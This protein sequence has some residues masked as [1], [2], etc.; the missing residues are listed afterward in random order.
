MKPRKHAFVLASAVAAALA[1]NPACT[2][3]RN[4]VDAEGKF[5]TMDDVDDSLASMIEGERYRIAIDEKDAMKGGAKPVVTIVEFS[6]FQCPFCS[7]VTATFDE[8]IKAFPEDVRLVFKQFPLPMH[9]DAQLAAEASLAA[10]EQGKFWEFHDK[11]FANQKALTRADLEKYATELALDLEKFKKALDDGTYKERVKADMELGKKFQVRS[12]PS[13]FVN[14]KPQKGAMNID[15]LKKIVEEEKAA[16]QKLVD[17][18]AKR[19][20]IY[21]RIMRAAKDTR[22]APKQED[23]PR[24]GAPDPA[25]NYAVTTGEGRP[26][27]GKPDA[28]VT[29]VEFSDFQCP[30]CSRVNPAIQQIKDAHPNDVRI[31]FKQLPLPMHPQ[32]RI[33]A[34]ASLAADRQGKFWDMYDKLFAN[35][36]DL[37]EENFAK[38][39]GEIGLNVDKFK[40]DLADPKL[41]D[42]TKEDEATARK[43]GANG[44]PAFFVNGRHLSGAQPFEKFDALIKEEKAKAEKFLAEKKV[45]KKDLYN[46][47]IKGFET[48]LKQ[49]PVADHKRR[50]VETAGLPAK[51]NTK[52]PKVTIV[53]CSDFDCPFCKRATTTVDQIAKE[54]GDK[55]AIFFRQYPLP[56]HK[57]AEPAHRAA[58]AAHKQGKFWEM[59]DVLFANKDKRDDAALEGF[60]QQVGL[61]VSKWKS[62]FND[63]ATAAK[64]QADIEACKKADVQGAPG[65]LINGRLLSGAQPF[66][67]FK[68]V[69]DEE[70][71]GGFE[72]KQKAG[73]VAKPDDAKK[74]AVAKKADKPAD[75]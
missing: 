4:A 57:N 44:T 58:L 5:I 8:A 39:A 29:I 31:V 28:L 48:E 49:P 65:F 66:E 70:L 41:E 9:K 34:K 68:E 36:K 15:A 11:M 46:E 42:I 64:L 27:W 60:A 17:G 62:D 69:I 6:D 24:P 53:E 2:G 16:A 54:F 23:R 71:A 56:M 75:K 33:A 47:M 67:R 74:D 55:V 12:T 61:D 1:F 37:N 14:G 32:A 20:E 73:T 10:H 26:S 40:K 63:A 45:A 13:F 50:P 38:W 25:T 18:G 19:E 72:A 22:E 30:F 59:H 51:G 21:A 7:K 35:Q 43:F 52:N 3:K